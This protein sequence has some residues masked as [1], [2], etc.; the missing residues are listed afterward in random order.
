MTTRRPEQVLPF[1][2]ENAPRGTSHRPHRTLAERRERYTLAQR[3][4]EQHRITYD[5]I[6]DLSGETLATCHRALDPTQFR[7][8]RWES[9]C[10][11]RFAACLLLQRRGAPPPEKLWDEYDAILI[12]LITG[13]LPPAA[14]AGQ[15]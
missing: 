3:L 6:S 5:A 7:R 9:L 13:P 1:H 15:K 10:R 12:A 14:S 4:I 8:M 2:A 11:I